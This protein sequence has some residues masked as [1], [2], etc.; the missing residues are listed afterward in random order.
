MTALSL[1][2][3]GIKKQNINTNLLPK[4]LQPKRIKATLKTTLTLV[5]T[6]IIF[7]G[8]W[9]TNQIHF[10]NKKLA[11]LEI[12]LQ[13]IKGK[14]SRLEKI[15]LEYTSIQKHIN[16]LNAIS[17]TYPAKLYLLSKLSKILPK[18][19]W[20][21][22]IKFQKGEMEI[23]GFS[24]TASKLI[25]LIEQSPSFKKTGFVGSIISEPMG[26]KFTIRA[27]LESNL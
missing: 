18:D 23:K 7:L 10:K 9:V 19:T 15:D 12:Q 3:R 25:P 4:N 26:E 13:E 8:V 11:S 20:L 6:V 14:V 21:T 16:I 1:A 17:N 22:N 24:P 5:A 2:T 27:K